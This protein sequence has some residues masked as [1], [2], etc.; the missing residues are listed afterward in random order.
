VPLDR[1][2]VETTDAGRTWHPFAYSDEAAAG[3]PSVFVFADDKV[4][5]ATVRGDVR[6]TV[7]GGA[8]FVMVKSSWP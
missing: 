3:V 4:G 7:D 6:R 5:Y 2:R 8:H 1:R